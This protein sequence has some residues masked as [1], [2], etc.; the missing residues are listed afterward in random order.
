M[1]WGG[2][3]L[4]VAALYERRPAVTDAATAQARY[5]L[6]AVVSVDAG[7]PVP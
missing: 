3:E 1:S 2:F 7:F 6:G 4:V 5:E